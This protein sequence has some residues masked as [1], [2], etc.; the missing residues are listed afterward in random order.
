MRLLLSSAGWE[1]PE[2]QPDQKTWRLLLQANFAVISVG[3]ALGMTTGCFCR[4]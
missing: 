3:N 1:L 2:L 4:S